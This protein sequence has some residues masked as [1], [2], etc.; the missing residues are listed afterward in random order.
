M[1]LTLAKITTNHIL[2]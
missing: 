1:L 2:K